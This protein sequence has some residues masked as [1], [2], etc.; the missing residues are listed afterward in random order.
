MCN[1]HT[2]THIHARYLKVSCF[3]LYLIFYLFKVL[4]T[5]SMMD[6]QALLQ[7]DKIELDSDS[8]HRGPK[9]AHVYTGKGNSDVGTCQNSVYSEEG[10]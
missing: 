7:V 3:I 4:H 10:N 8:N 1:A 2:N 5:Y 9:S 6:V